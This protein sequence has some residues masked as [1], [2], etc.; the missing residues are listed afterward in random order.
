MAESERRAREVVLQVCIECGTEYIIEDGE[1]AREAPCAKCGNVV[2]RSF[3]AMAGSD[4]AHD[5]FNATTERDTATDAGA[6][7]VTAGDLRDL[8]RL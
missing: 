4:D 2:Y 6:G 5:D 7:D 3:R 8:E 1:P